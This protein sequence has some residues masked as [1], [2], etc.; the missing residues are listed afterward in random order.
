MP[1]YKVELIH[2]FEVEADNENE[3]IAK[4]E[5]LGYGDALDCYIGDVEIKQPPYAKN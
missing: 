3:A 1:V 2:E 5:E 4:A